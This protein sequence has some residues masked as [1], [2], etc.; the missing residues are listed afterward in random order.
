MKCPYCGKEMEQGYFYSPTWDFCWTPKNEKVHSFRNRPKDYEVLLLK[1][2][3][4]SIRI[5]VYRCI[6]CRKEVID[7]NDLQ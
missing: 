7:E 5:K 1:G 6:D 3:W 2:G 4:N